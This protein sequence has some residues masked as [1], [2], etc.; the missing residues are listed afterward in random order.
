MKFKGL[1]P[2]L[3]QHYHGIWVEETGGRLSTGRR[4]PCRNSNRTS[5]ENKSE[6]VTLLI[7]TVDVRMNT[8]MEK[9]GDEELHNLYFLRNSNRII[10]SG[11]L[12][13]AG[14]RAVTGLCIRKM[15]SV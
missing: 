9:L 5:P 4:C 13:W 1:R 10:K 6:A 14:H 12:R 11:R 7:N 2:N 3:R 8:L 15:G